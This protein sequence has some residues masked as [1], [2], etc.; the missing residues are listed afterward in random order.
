MNVDYIIQKGSEIMQITKEQIEHVAKLA[1]LNLTEA[2]KEKYAN[3]LGSIIEFVNK[4]NQLDTT[5]VQQTAHV[6]PINNV[7]R[8]DK[9][10]PSFDREKILMNASVQKDGCVLVPKVVE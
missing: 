5:D 8:E 6:V 1:R 9:V 4:L 7:F 10:E 3:E 2:E